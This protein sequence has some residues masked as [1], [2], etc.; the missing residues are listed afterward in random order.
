MWAPNAEDI[1]VVGDFNHW[2]GK[3]HLLTRMTN[4]GLWSGFFTDI[5]VNV[6]YKYEIT[7]S[8]GLVLMKADPYAL[9][10]ELRPATASITPSPTRYEWTDQEWQAKKLNLMRTH[11]QSLFMKCT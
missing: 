5:P 4:E 11:H 1:R 7:A 9:Q 3:K 8:N 2:D 10:S 6:P